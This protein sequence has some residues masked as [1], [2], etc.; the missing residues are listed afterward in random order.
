MHLMYVG[1]KNNNP[2]G[3]YH[4]LI[5]GLQEILYID[6]RDG[7]II[8]RFQG[9]DHGEFILHSCL[10]GEL[11]NY[12]ISGSEDGQIYIWH[13]DTG[14]LVSVLSGH[15]AGS[16]NAVAWNWK[17]PGMFASASDDRTVR[18]WRRP[19]DVPS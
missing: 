6:L 2:F 10:G 4:S 9:H 1:G 17:R 8:R 5:C 16:V 11:E 13:R 12:V 19:N 3:S 14:S 15:G 7:T 18:I